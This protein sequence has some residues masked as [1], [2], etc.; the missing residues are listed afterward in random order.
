MVAE[1][2]EDGPAQEMLLTG[3][4][5][6]TFNGMPVRD[7]RSLPNLVGATK[8]GS[9]VNVDILRQGVEKSVAV[10]ICELKT[11]QHAA[12]T[13]GPV[14]EDGAES[15]KLSAT[16]SALSPEIRQS[17]GL[18]DTVN[19][20]VITSVKADGT[21]AQTGLKAGDVIMQVGGES[22]TGAAELITALDE[23]NTPSALL[24]VNRHGDP[25]F[26]GVKLPA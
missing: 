25:F 9:T 5:I 2:V 8:A 15:E 11:E 18:D 12:N 19:G 7:S 17:L 23:T 4:L 20:A 16:I 13:N 22:V 26:V 14:V 10:K 6:V 3:D 24:L 21:A 1:V